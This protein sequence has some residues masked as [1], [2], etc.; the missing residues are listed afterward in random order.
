VLVEDG[1]LATGAIYKGQKVGSFGDMGCFSLASGKVLG[2]LG[3]G[4]GVTTDSED[5]FLKL[6]QVRNYGSAKSPYREKDPLADKDLP[7]DMV[8]KGL[9]DRMDTIQAA[10]GLVKLRVHERDLARR[11]AIAAVYDEVLADSPCTFTKVPEYA[12]HC[13]RVYPLKVEPEIRDRYIEELRAKGI[14]AG[15]HY[16]PPDHLTGF[17][18]E[19]GY[20][21]G[22][23]PATEAAADAIVCLPSHPYMEPDEVWYT[24]T[25]ARD[26]LNSLS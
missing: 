23:L 19:Q 7:H 10:A 1:S 25:Q 5:F 11:Q 8:A 21:R 9:N 4:G 2:V 12:T 3:S 15:A 14:Q 22:H 16:S 6:N 13:Y 24:A 18:T 26:I 20:G 17:F